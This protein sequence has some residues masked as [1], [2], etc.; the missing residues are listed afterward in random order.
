MPELPEVQEVRRT[1][2]P[3]VLNVPIVDIKI[4]RKSYIR[5]GAGSLHS[6]IGRKV[7]HTARHGKKL[8][9]IF[10]DG[11]VLLIHL[12]MSGRI[13][14]CER[15]T[16]LA[17]HTHFSMLLATGLEFRMRDPRRFGGLWHYPHW[18]AAEKAEITGKMG[19]DALAITAGH[20]A[21]WRTMHSRLKSHLLSQRTVAGL[22]NIYVDESLWLAQLHPLQVLSKIRPRHHAVLADA[23]HA[24]LNKSI[25]MG[26]TT[27]RDYRNVAQQ[28]GR[29]AQS[30]CVY[31]RAGKPCLRCGAKL[32]SNVIGGRTTVYCVRCQK[33]IR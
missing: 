22:G 28:R 25:S 2:E 9:C 15:A 20:F 19:V 29:F 17:P 24:V 21:P 31:G 30:L 8:F 13:D 14:C 7:H 11:Q 10:D 27:L 26:G 6:L 1:L 4:S 23:I 16:P 12:G 32:T 5:A 3:F 33:I 18:A